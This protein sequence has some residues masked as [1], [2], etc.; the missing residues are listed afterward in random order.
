MKSVVVIFAGGAGQRMGSEIPKQ[1]LKVCGK[2]ILL[3]TLEL[4]EI[5]NN[6]DDIYIACLEEYIPYVE[7]LVR[8]HFVNKVKKVFPGGV[9][10]Q[11]SIF[12]GLT[13]VKK[14][15]E[16]AIVLLHDGVRPLV[17]Q[18]TI[19]SCIESV[20]KYGSAVTVTPCT[21][22]P[23]YSVNGQNV[24]GMPLR[25][26][27]YTAQAPQGYFLNDILE[28]HLIERRENPN[29]TGI[30]DSCGLMFKHG[31]SS[32]LV[33]GNKG[34]IKV[35]TPEDY[36]TLIG[37]YNSLDYYQ[38]FELAGNNS[39]YNPRRDSVVQRTKRNKGGNQ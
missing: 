9:S 19:T 21:E 18:E 12:I 11:D 14:D 5:N 2:E 26:E 32:H 13:E 7:D 4:F 33:L 3:H 37:N 31:V 15:H 17:S 1:F 29:Y 22:T 35:T 34:N 30:V 39:L 6:I 38:L 27:T 8:M 10:G 16:N 25:S 36:C 28:K 20:K 23:I 24:T